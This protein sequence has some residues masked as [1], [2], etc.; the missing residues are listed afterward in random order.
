MGPPAA[1]VPSVGIWES[2]REASRKE[3]LWLHPDPP[4]RQ[5]LS[6]LPGGSSRK[7]EAEEPQ[8]EGWVGWGGGTC[9]GCGSNQ[10]THTLEKFRV[11]QF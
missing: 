4:G 3:Q 5:P 8:K 2:S 11:A 1:P 10:S 6:G 9:L 7:M